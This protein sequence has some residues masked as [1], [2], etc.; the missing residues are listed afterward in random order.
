MNFR[1]TRSFPE[2][3]T[4]EEIEQFAESRG[5]SVFYMLF[6][7]CPLA[8]LADEDIKHGDTV[9]ACIPKQIYNRVE[10]VW[11][12]RIYKSVDPAKTKGTLFEVFE[13]C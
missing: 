9:T 4:C 11:E 3:H 12:S 2:P 5:V 6:D 10:M 1:I 13:L 7:D 8:I